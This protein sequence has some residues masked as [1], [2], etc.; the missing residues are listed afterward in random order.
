MRPGFKC[1]ERWGFV[2]QWLQRDCGVLVA[3]LH[4]AFDCAVDNLQVERSRV[5]QDKAGGLARRRRKSL[6]R[7]AG[8][9]HAKASLEQNL[10]KRIFCEVTDATQL[11]AAICARERS[12]VCEFLQMNPGF[13]GNIG[14]IQCRPA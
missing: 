9:D 2:A 14:R 11:F 12:T 1:K 7:E 13:L 10:S 8:G 5:F 4:P 3:N 6:Y